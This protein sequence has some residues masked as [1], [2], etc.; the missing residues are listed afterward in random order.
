MRVIYDIVTNERQ[1]HVIAGTKSLAIYHSVTGKTGS[2]GCVGAV[3]A[4][5]GEGGGWS[6]PVVS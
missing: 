4:A 5:A 3:A 6:G 2:S 1:K